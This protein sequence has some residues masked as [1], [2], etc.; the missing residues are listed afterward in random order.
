MPV[1]PNRVRDEKHRLGEETHAHVS[2]ETRK[3]CA[4]FE[5]Q[6]ESAEPLTR[7]MAKTFLGK[8]DKLYTPSS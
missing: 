4:A 1:T 7:K 5:R 3:L 2:E 6:M 8:L